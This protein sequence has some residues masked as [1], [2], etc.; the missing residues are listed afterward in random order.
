MVTS[1]D[2]R[3]WTSYMDFFRSNYTNLIKAFYFGGRFYIFFCYVYVM[4]FWI[5]YQ[6]PAVKMNFGFELTPQ[7]TYIEKR[8]TSSHL[9]LNFVIVQIFTKSSW[10]AVG[11]GLHFKVKWTSNTEK[12]LKNVAKVGLRNCY[13]TI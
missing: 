1:A 11:H 13:Q 6:K 5:S 4:I 7:K 3:K 10:V 8:K 2:R 12:P 9:Y